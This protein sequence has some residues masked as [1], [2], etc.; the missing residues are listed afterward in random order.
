MNIR[1]VSGNAVAVS[2]A[3]TIDVSDTDEIAV[4]VTGTWVATL[5]FEGSVDGTNYD[6]CVI[7]PLNGTVA[8]GSTTANLSWYARN[9]TCLRSFRVRC[10]AYTSGTATVTIT[11]GRLGRS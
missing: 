2:D 11:A 8:V 9:V 10:T 1:T 3:I 7:V 4:Q 5:S 6:A